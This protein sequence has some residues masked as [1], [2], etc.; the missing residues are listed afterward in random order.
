MSEAAAE[1]R[2]NSHTFMKL[3]EGSDVSQTAVPRGVQQAD[4]HL[5]VLHHLSLGDI[6]SLSVCG[7]L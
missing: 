6:N 4:V 7:G 3:M 1:N 5:Y 2:Q